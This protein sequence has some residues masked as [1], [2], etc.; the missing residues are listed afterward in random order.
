MCASSRF[1][2]D[3]IRRRA[4][5]TEL[6][7]RFCATVG[8][9]QRYGAGKSR[10]NCAMR[11]LLSTLIVIGILVIGLGFY[12]GWF[13]MSSPETEAGSHKVD[14]NLT[15]DP[16]KMKE[17]AKSVKTSITDLTD[18]VTGEKTPDD[19]TTAPVKSIN[20]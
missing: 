11:G 16:D 14:V 1:S 19:Q 5:V 7:E 13:A 12:R 8:F 18:K 17:D 15:V 20:P 6:V 2:D 3:K 4:D 9:R 10:R